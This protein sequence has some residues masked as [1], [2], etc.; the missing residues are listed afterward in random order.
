MDVLKRSLASEPRQ[1]QEATE[2]LRRPKGNAS[3]NRREEGCAEESGEAGALK[4]KKSW[5]EQS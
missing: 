4:P 5:V 3:A 2:R 1:G